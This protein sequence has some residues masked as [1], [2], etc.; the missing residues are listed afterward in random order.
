MEGI[1][2]KNCLKRLLR[3]SIMKIGCEILCYS[4]RLVNNGLYIAGIQKT[5]FAFYM[6]HP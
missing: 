4:I 3:G 6:S 2:K 1:D 5:M